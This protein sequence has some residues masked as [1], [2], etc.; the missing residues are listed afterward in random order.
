VNRLSFTLSRFRRHQRG[1]AAVEFAILAPILLIL[2]TG[3]IDLGIGFQ[4]KLEMQSALNSGLQH[5]MQTQGKD[6][7]TTRAVIA[8]G[9]SKLGPAELEASAFCK[10]TCNPGSDRFARASVA[11]PYRTPIFEMDMMLSGSFEVYVGQVE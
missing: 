6:I 7:T 4:R 9:L 1:N 11:M 10:S 3:T 8:H 5:V 2:V